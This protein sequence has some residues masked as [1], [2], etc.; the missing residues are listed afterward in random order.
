MD[1]VEHRNQM[2]DKMYRT[3]AEELSKT[4]DELKRVSNQL[5]ILEKELSILAVENIHKKEESLKQNVEK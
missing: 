2:Y 5:L 1:S 4:S 3:T